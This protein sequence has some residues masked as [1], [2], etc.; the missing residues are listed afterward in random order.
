MPDTY[1]LHPKGQ[2]NNSSAV[3]S[4]AKLNIRVF[5]IEHLITRLEGILMPDIINV[6]TIN[7]QG[8]SLYLDQ[9]DQNGK[10]PNSL[11]THFFFSFFLPLFIELVIYLFN[12][13]S[14][15]PDVSSTI[16]FCL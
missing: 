13:T 12:S 2:P 9:T 15:S 7:V 3:L 1:K 8:D 14:E 6:I 11:Y 4:I 5:V 10:R 16:F